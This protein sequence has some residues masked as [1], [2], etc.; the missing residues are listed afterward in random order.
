LSALILWTFAVLMFIGGLLSPV[1][2]DKL[3]FEFGAFALLCTG[4]FCAHCFG[5]PGFAPNGA[6][7]DEE[8]RK[9]LQQVVVVFGFTAACCFLF[10]GIFSMSLSGKP[11]T[12][13]STTE[14][15]AIHAL[16]ISFGIYFAVLGAA[17]WRWAQDT[18][19]DQ[20]VARSRIGV[21]ALMG[22]CIVAMIGH[23]VYLAPR[24]PAFD[25]PESNG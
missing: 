10:F 3:A 19:A 23:T 15:N 8:N 6:A 16:V 18:R 12:P 11:S 24:L 2:P 9:A 25:L 14:R 5:A 7:T 1:S 20:R 17:V 21:M 4:A 13:G 22:V